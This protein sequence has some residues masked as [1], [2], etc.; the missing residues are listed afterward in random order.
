M[1]RQAEFTEQ[2]VASGL[3]D[4]VNELWV[5]RILQQSGVVEPRMLRPLTIALI[6]QV[7]AL[8]WMT[9]GRLVGSGE[10]AAWDLP[11]NESI[12]RVSAEWRPEWPAEALQPGQIV[13]LANTA[14]GDEIARKVIEDGLTD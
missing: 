9:P 12:L 7:V 6:A 14:T 4:W 11:L 5:V 10:F 13:W 3:D 1:I 8:N 2:I